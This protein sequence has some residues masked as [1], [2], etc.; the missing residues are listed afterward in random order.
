MGELFPAGRSSITGSVYAVAVQAGASRSLSRYGRLARRAPRAWA[1]VALAAGLL[2][3]APG[4]RAERA[5]SLSLIVNFTPAG[6]VSV[7][8]PDGTPVGTTSGSPTVIPAGFYT[9]VLNGP[10]DCI[11]LPLFELRGPG[12]NINDDMLGG[13]VEV[14]DLYATF[15]PNTTYTWHID[16]NEAVVY[17]FRTSAVVSGTQSTG[18]GSTGSGSGSGTTP[19]SQDIVGSA[20]V[21]F[22]GT[23]TARVTAGGMLTLAYKGKRITSLRAGRYTVAVNDRSSSDSFVLQKVNHKPMSLTGPSFIGKRSTS[24]TL[25]AGKWLVLPHPGKTAYSIVVS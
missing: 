23:V 20:I 10:G 11:N 4:A 16:R 24:V 5:A 18:S 17:S 19:T 12:V 15:L 13:E 7:T 9:L 25:T 3:L 22:R 14:H 8:L 21:P 2:A 6:A 1:A